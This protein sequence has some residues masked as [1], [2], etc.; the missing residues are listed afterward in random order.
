MSQSRSLMPIPTWSSEKMMRPEA[1]ELSP[2]RPESECRRHPTALSPFQQSPRRSAP[3]GT[4]P[5]ITMLDRWQVEAT[6]MIKHQPGRRR[7]S[8]RRGKSALTRWA[9]KSPCTA[10]SRRCHATPPPSQH[11]N[12][13]VHQQ[14]ALPLEAAG[15]SGEGAVAAED[16]MAGNEDGDRVPPHR[17]PDC[18]DRLR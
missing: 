5:S 13:L 16:A 12:P 10:P 4:I 3:R 11:Q 7:E 14:P 15:E 8:S 6:T 2:T 9:G 17:G 18:P 1:E